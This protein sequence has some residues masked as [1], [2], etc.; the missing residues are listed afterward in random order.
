VAQ[1]AACWQSSANWPGT[2]PCELQYSHTILT[3]P[4]GAVRHAGLSTARA[5]GSVVFAGAQDHVLASE[6]DD[7]NNDRIERAA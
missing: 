2:D 1:L 4:G 3:A 5:S 7:V 6:P